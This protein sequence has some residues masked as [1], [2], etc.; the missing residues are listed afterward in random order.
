MINKNFSFGH[1]ILGR[2]F[3]DSLFGWENLERK[4]NTEIMTKKLLRR[5]EAEHF[6]HFGEH[7]GEERKTLK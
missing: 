2:T 7:W 4:R 1:P 6:G 5:G 3:I